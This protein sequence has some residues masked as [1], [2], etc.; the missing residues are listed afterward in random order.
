MSYGIVNLNVLLLFP[1]HSFHYQL[2]DESG[3]DGQDQDAAGE[4]VCTFLLLL[5]ICWLDLFGLDLYLK[6][7]WVGFAVVPPTHWLAATAHE[8]LKGQCQNIMVHPS[9]GSQINTM[10]Y[11]KL[12]W[13]LCRDIVDGNV[14]V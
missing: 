7:A 1:G 12:F 11:F 9:S 4:K 6:E 5:A 13:R 2:F 14:L 3:M 8:T 10:L